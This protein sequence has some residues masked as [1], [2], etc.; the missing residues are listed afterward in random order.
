MMPPKISAETTFALG[1]FLAANQQLDLAKHRYAIDPYVKFYRNLYRVW[2]HHDADVA[3][4]VLEQEADSRDYL[5]ATQDYNAIARMVD[6]FGGRSSDDDPAVTKFDGEGFDPYVIARAGLE[7][8]PGMKDA[9]YIRAALKQ[10]EFQKRS[11][12]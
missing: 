10:Y 4:E 1:E 7:Q 2:L 11:S 9:S 8:N 12:C 6:F 3:I 5:S